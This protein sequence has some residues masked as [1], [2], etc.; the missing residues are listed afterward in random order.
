LSLRPLPFWDISTAYGVFVTEEYH[1]PREGALARVRRIVD[2]GANVGM[3]CIYLLDRYPDAHI[4]AFEPHPLHVEMLRKTLAMNNLSERV[5]LHAAAA[6]TTDHDCF[7]TDDEI[8]S[9]ITAEGG[10]GRLATRVEDFFAAVG[11]A[12]IDLLKMD[13]E[14]GEYALL[15]D[16]R[17]ERLQI[18]AM[19]M[20]WHNTKEKPQGRNWCKQRLGEMGYEVHDGAVV[21]PEH[22][23]LWAFPSRSATHQHRAAGEV[24][25]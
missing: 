3:T 25:V 19:V 8:R 2:L 21:A 18:G 13:I 16:P 11:D 24:R 9:L 17:F 20:E 10:T 1:C 23:L 5:T 14:G 12:P 15:D 6:G 22:G 7:V 4:I